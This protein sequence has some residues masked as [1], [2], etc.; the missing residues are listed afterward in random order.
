M[1]NNSEQGIGRASIRAFV[2]GVVL[3][4]VFAWYTVMKDNVVPTRYL[5]A[6]VISI[7]PFMLLFC[8][9]LLIN[10]I[11]RRLP[12]LRG[13][14]L[15]R[16]FSTS[17]M[18]L[19]FVMC[20]VGAGTAS[21]GLAGRL[22]PLVS[23][24]SNAKVNTLQSKMDINVLPFLNED[25]FILEDGVH[26]AA[27]E[28]RKAH[29]A[30]V[31]AENRYRS[32]RDLLL[33]QSELKRIEAEQEELMVISD[34]EKRKALMRP[35][36]YSHAR[37]TRLIELATENWEKI[38]GGEDPAVV[39]ETYP[40]K[41]SELREARETL[42]QDLMDLNQDASD[43]VERIRSGLPKGDRA[44]PGFIYVPGEGRLS[45]IGRFRRMRVGGTVLKKLDVLI[46]GVAA[47]AAGNAPLPH[48]V[49]VQLREL[50]DA[51]QPV[52]TLSGLAEYRDALMTDKAELESAWAEKKAE[53]AEVRKKRRFAGLKESTKL[54]EQVEALVESVEEHEEEVKLLQ[55][56]IGRHVE[57]VEKAYDLVKTA[58]QEL[59]D[60]ALAAE[61]GSLGPADMH[62]Q[63]LQIRG[64]FRQFDASTRRFLAGDGDWDVWLG[65]VANWLLLIFLGYLVFMSFNTLVY[66]QW[67]HNEK[68]LYPLAE[69]TTLVA[70]G[71]E[72]S[73]RG[74]AIYKTALFWC[75]FAWA[76]GVLGW[77]HLVSLEIVPNISKISLGTPL[78][79]YVG[80][81]A[82]RGTEGSIF[83]IV[84]AVIG[85]SFLLPANVSSS[86]WG[87]EVAAMMMYVVMNWVGMGTA[88]WSKHGTMPR[89][90]MGG[91][92]MLVFGAMTLWTCR[93]YLLCAFRPGALK[94]LEPDE[95]TELRVS[96]F[97]FLAGALTL[98]LVLTVRFEVSLFYTVIYMLLALVI[99]IVT[100]RTVAEGGL[101][102]L[103]C[104][105]TGLDFVTKAVG[106]VK[107][108]CA[109]VLFAPLIIFDSVLLGSMRGFMAPVMANSLKVRE[110]IRIRR[111]AFHGAVA[112]GIL[113]AVVV[114][115][116]TLVIV[117]YDV[118]ANSLNTSI[119]DAS[120]SVPDIGAMI[121]NP[122]QS[123]PVHV[124]W[125]L[126][127][128][129]LMAGILIARRSAFWIPHP[130]GLVALI[131][132]W[133][134][135]FWASI[136]IGWI[137][138]SLVSKYCA[139][140]QYLRIRCFFIGLVVGHVF[141]CL[142]GWDQ[143]HWAMPLWL[144]G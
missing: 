84:F 105:L 26:D 142:C 32:A 137:C 15:F 96:S 123:N 56:K 132:P 97:L 127:G 100:V 65:P 43:A 90:N 57:P 106:A 113:V 3:S 40:A 69:I 92:A 82:L 6:H 111:L 115:I 21:F 81:G 143:M 85:I 8:S 30:F 14:R 114:S 139:E 87:F 131:N 62:E 61:G 5:A 60:T 110:Y 33:G 66:R 36:E 67:A 129:A 88:V 119:H 130:I 80:S 108:W 125:M 89:I 74:P 59:R 134:I 48:D 51:L 53:L 47:A 27:V 144:A 83:A 109:P 98:T 68:L 9:V 107:A 18:L 11:L 93:K 140:E 17:E 101:I 54:D 79:A 72:S 52:T 99:T 58:Q 44:V 39:D 126:V 4:G 124:R 22:V 104:G 118:G 42:R 23:S 135:T 29:L 95:R 136:M 117:C 138:K 20:A 112:T 25:F 120:K 94:N 91:G 50:A 46:D 133:M 71:T 37:T 41:I 19:V 35:L 75:G 45:Y 28:V 55:E 31:E 10:P 77:N 2:I 38:G 12:F 16:P 70:T 122:P 73:G 78:Y 76:A 34:V 13:R 128:A 141:A 102:G 24:V 116:V 64:A 63:L 103:H 49:A 86:L 1:S 121:A 7:L